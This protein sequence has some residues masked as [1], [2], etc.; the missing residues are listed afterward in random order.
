VGILSKREDVAARLLR[1]TTDSGVDLV[2]DFVGTPYF[3]RNVALLAPDGVL[4]LVGVLGGWQGAVDLL[5]IIMKRLE[6]KGFSM[7]GQPDE[8]KAGIVARFR[9]HWLDPI[10][11]GDIRPVI[12]GTWPLHRVADAHREMEANLNIGKILLTCE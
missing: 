1:E 11:R 10:G 2:I 8:R 3:D 7:R 4:M 5:P 6:I 9:K 12:H